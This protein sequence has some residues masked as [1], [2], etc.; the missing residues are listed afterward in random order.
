M[1]CSVAR[2][3]LITEIAVAGSVSSPLKAAAV[4]ASAALSARRVAAAGRGLTTRRLTSHDLV[5][6][7]HHRT[8]CVLLLRAAV[9][10]LDIRANN[11]LNQ[12][13]RKVGG[14]CTFVVI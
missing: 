4:M 2:C 13:A 12:S 14:C 1:A 3:T 5:E 11:N 10:G 8:S 7:N 9:H 6:L